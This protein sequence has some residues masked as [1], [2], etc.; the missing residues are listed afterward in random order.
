MRKLA[1]LATVALASLPLAAHAQRGPAPAPAS[2]DLPEQMTA[3]RPAGAT[4]A[5]APGP[6]ASPANLATIPP[7]ATAPDP[8]P[9]VLPAAATP[10]PVPA[11]APPPPPAPTAAEQ[12]FQ[13]VLQ[14]LVPATPGMVRDF[15]G[16]VN[17]IGRAAAAPAAGAA[18]VARTRSIQL[19]LRPGEAMPQLRLYPGNASVLT[20]SDMT[21]APWPVLSATVGNPAAYALA[22]AGERGRTNMVVVSPI[23]HHATVAN[24][25]VTL[26]GHPVPV[27]FSLATGGGDVDHRLDVGVRARGPNAVID[28]IVSSSLAPTNDS[29]VQSFVDGTP[30]RGARRLTT[31]NRDVEAWRLGDMVYVRTPLELLS[32]AYTARAR[33]VSGTSVYTLVEAPVLLVSQDGRVSSVTVV[34]GSGAGR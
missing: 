4:Q 7:P 12:A 21:G 26:V 6:V 24:L 28:T 22:E 20:F 1:L 32:P 34:A 33:S 14:Q 8:A 19:T 16:Q 31:S 23:Q 17:A 3:V 5:A 25:V 15:R 30:P 2:S 9:L 10:A 13:Q 18:P 29:T 27:I 11:A